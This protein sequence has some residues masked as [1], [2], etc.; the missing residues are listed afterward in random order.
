[1]LGGNCGAN[2][3]ASVAPVHDV[4][5]CNVDDGPSPEAPGL[6]LRRGEEVQEAAPHGEARERRVLSPIE[7]RK[8]Q[9]LVE[10]HGAAH[11]VGGQGHGAE[12]FDVGLL[13]AGHS[14]LRGEGLV[15]LGGHDEVVAVEVAYLMRP[16]GNADAAP[17]GDQPWMMSL[18]LGD[19]PDPAR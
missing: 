6:G 5:V 9:R 8:A 3:T 4:D 13:L 16:P 18:L 17:L 19:G 10:A 14:T 1:M 12:G 11:V 7:H 2:P 15:G